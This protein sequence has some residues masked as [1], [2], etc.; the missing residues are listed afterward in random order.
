[1]RILV[2]GALGEVGRTVSS[3][4]EGLGHSVVR[5]SARADLLGDDAI[6]SLVAA[7]EAV[8]EARV[9]VVLNCA[10]RGDRRL[11][12]RPDATATSVLAPALARSGVPGVLLSTTRV[13]EGVEAD[14]A[15][16]ALAVPTTPYGLANAANEK[17]WLDLGGPSAHVVRITNYFAPPLAL[18]SPQAGLLPWSLVT[19]GLAT[20]HIGVRSGPSLTKEFV[21]ARDLAEA[22]LLIVTDPSS[23]RVCSTTPG[24]ALSLQELVLA[25]QGAFADL[26][27]LV[28]SASF[29]P[30]GPGGPRCLPGWLAS[31]GW[32]GAVDLDLVQS[33]IREWLRRVG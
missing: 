20:G 18:D 2:A 11:V 19:E 5:V 26:G 7:V 3:A 10:G 27:L 31:R 12:D 4:L 28:P 8:D 15:D 33:T 29:G 6:L 21:S 17:A 13:M 25:C 23:A 9:D 32:G 16:D 14:F 24:T 22:V 1:M 30:D